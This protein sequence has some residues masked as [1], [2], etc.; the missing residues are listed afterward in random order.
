[1]ASIR[2]LGSRCT[3][4]GPARRSIRLRTRGLCPRAHTPP[5]PARTS[6]MP[7]RAGTRP[8]RRRVASTPCPDDTERAAWAR[9]PRACRSSTSRTN[10]EDSAGALSALPTPAPV[11]GRPGPGCLL[12]PPATIERFASMFFH[13]FAQPVPTDRLQAP[14]LA[15]RNNSHFYSRMGAGLEVPRSSSAVGAAN[16]RITPGRW[17]ANLLGSSRR[18]SRP[19]TYAYRRNGY[20][21][22]HVGEPDVEDRTTE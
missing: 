3:T 11:S 7:S 21:N 16:C 14:G 15:V 1:M 10:V 12:P 20:L 9:G 4:I 18:G 8:G 17:L 13:I 5:P 2:S 6:R 22:K 19:I